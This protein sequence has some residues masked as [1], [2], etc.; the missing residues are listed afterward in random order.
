M[1]QTYQSKI[2]IPTFTSTSIRRTI[3]L[4]HFDSRRSNAENRSRP[5]TRG[6]HESGTT[7]IPPQTAR[8]ERERERTRVAESKNSGRLL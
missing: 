2:I 3:A 7:R 6:G 5:P 8:R 4:P 1:D